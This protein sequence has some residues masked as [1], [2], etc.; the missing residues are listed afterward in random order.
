MSR[1][2]AI[3][4]ILMILTTP[5]NAQVS[6]RTVREVLTQI[7][8]QRLIQYARGLGVPESAIA[9]YRRCINQQDD[10]DDHGS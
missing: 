5:A 9:Q 8:L 10:R 7:S 6:C 2:L 4:A 1:L 3:T